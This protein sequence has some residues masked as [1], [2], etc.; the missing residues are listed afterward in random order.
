MPARDTKLASSD[1]GSWRYIFTS[2]HLLQLPAGAV[3][4][5]GGGNPIAASIK[6]RAETI[7]SVSTGNQVMNSAN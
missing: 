1:F 2:S 4:M 5:F 7:T 6:K 3:S